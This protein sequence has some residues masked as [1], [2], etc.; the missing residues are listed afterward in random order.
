MLRLAGV[1]R[2]DFDP[3]PH[4]HG[5]GG[6]AIAV[7]WQTVGAAVAV[8]VALLVAARFASRSGR[9]SGLPALRLDDLLVIAVAIIPGALIGG[10]ILHGLD[11]LDYYRLDPVRLLD[12]SQGSLSLLGAVVGGTLS[13]AFICRLVETWPARW[14]DVASTSLLLLIGIGKLAQF[15]GGGGQG[16]PWDGAWAVAF[17]GAG[18]WLSIAPATP[19]VPA[20]L[21]VLTDAA[22]TEI[23]TLSLH[24]GP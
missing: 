3:L 16:A 1:V 19:A 11:Y 6:P 7:P 15:A 4:L 12:P 21:F 18:P 13:G 8:F 14:A 5:P 24:A 9:R 10:R 23:Y 17:E 2:L 22:T 20:Q